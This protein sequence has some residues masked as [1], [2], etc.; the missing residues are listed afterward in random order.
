MAAEETAKKTVGLTTKER[1]AF[2]AT[3]RLGDGA[4]S[5]AVAD[6]PRLKIP[7]PVRPDYVYPDVWEKQTNAV[8]RL[9]S[10]ADATARALPGQAAFEVVPEPR[11]IAISTRAVVSIKPPR[12]RQRVWDAMTPA[13]RQ[14]FGISAKKAGQVKK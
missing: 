7:S 3:A 12:I 14:E 11:D 4:I 5:R 8:K 6:R 13:M 2:L 10:S 1:N 9:L